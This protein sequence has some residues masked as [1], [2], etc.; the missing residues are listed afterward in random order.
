LVKPA[1]QPWVET[2]TPEMDAAKHRA[3]QPN[4]ARRG[5]VLEVEG[6][7]AAFMTISLVYVIQKLQHVTKPMLALMASE[8]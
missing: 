1:Y 4:K 8:D 7:S 5:C 6:N 3:S 2:K